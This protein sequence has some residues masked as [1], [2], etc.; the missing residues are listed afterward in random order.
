MAGLRGL[1]AA[2]NHERRPSDI[3]LLLR[4]LDFGLAPYGVSARDAQ[5]IYIDQTQKNPAQ[6]AEFIPR[7]AQLDPSA[8]VF[9]AFRDD[10]YLQHH[11][12]VLVE[13][14]AALAAKGRTPRVLWQEGD[15]SLLMSEA[16]RT[17]DQ[18]E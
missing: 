9:V 13:I 4:S 2:I 8:R 7:I 1:A 6:L 15:L 17:S 10:Y 11:R 16:Q 12:D 18:G 14:I 5:V 3:V